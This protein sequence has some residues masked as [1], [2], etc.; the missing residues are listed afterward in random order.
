MR[1]EGAALI[2]L[3]IQ[4]NELTIATAGPQLI[5]WD[6]VAALDPRAS[7]GEY[8]VDPLRKSVWS[9]LLWRK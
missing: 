1:N 7:E 5:F 4:M 8:V 6:R 9:G 2:L 3:K